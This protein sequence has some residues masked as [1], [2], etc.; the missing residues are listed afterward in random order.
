MWID[1]VAAYPVRNAGS[2]TCTLQPADSDIKMKLKLNS[3]TNVTSARPAEAIRTGVTPVQN[4]A[5]RA[6][7]DDDQRTRA[8][9]KKSML[10]KKQF[11]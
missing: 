7:N 9:N 6:G 4:G 8:G 3:S 10:Y 5:G 2:G 11:Q 1:I